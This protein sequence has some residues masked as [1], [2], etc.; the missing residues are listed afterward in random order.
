M[1]KFIPFVLSVAPELIELVREVIRES[2]GDKAE[3]KRIM[4]ALRVPLREQMHQARAKRDAEAKAKFE[5]G[6]PGGTKGEA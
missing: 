5:G 4:T 2:E 6:T 1:T 3:G